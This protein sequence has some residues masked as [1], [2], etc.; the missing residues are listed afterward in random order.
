LP[1]TIQPDY[2]GYLSLKGKER[3]MAATAD[4]LPWGTLA[5]SQS[6]G[7]HGAGL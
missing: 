6:N 3:Q 1:A 2:N 5:Y 4:I 7:N